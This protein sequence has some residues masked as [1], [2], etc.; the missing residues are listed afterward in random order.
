MK[1]APLNDLASM[2]C[3]LIVTITRTTIMS[4]LFE[5]QPVVRYQKR[6]AWN[7]NSKNRPLLMY[8]AHPRRKELLVELPRLKTHCWNGANQPTVPTTIIRITA[9][10]R[11]IQQS[12]DLA[13]LAKA[14]EAL[15]SFTGY[16]CAFGFLVS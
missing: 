5:N 16:M 15:I 14:A 7:K 4:G 2:D 6:D 1:C 9:A 13:H 3:V 10:S 11:H 12:P 8:R